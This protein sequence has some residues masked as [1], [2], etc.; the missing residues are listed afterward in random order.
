MHILRFLVGALTG[1]VFGFV[2]P[3]L[4]ATLRGTDAPSAQDAGEHRSGG[5]GRRRARR[6]RRKTATKS[7]GVK[8]G[9][10]GG[11]R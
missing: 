3:E 2:P 9:D 11:V 4:I 10:P 8:A 1:I 7:G 6:P 5:G